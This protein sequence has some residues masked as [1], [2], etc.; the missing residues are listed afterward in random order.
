MN[1][2][3]MSDD[4]E[5]DE[6]EVDIYSPEKNREVLIHRLTDLDG[7]NEQ[8]LNGYEISMNQADLH[9]IIEK[10]ILAN[11]VSPHQ[12]LIEIPSVSQGFRTEGM[13]S[14]T[15]ARVEQAH[16]ITRTR[17]NDTSKEADPYNGR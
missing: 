1:Y 16:G 13:F 10:R 14:A 17:V 12:I 2:L 5:Y 9:D 7:K 11:Q 3:E 8:V 15:S 6:I 4:L